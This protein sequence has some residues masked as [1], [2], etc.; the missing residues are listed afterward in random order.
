VHGLVALSMRAFGEE[1]WAIRAP[2]AILSAASVPVLYLLS[3]EA[4]E[5]DRSPRSGRASSS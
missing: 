2:P 5:T 3:R 4:F 1:S